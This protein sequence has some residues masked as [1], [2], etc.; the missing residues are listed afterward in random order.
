MTE[1]Y[2]QLRAVHIGCAVLTITIFTLRG[3]AMLVDSPLTQ[4][5]VARWTSVT[6]D[7]VLLTTA[8]MLTTVIH[9]Y[10]FSTGWLTVKVTLLVVYIVLG[11]IA[12]GR[13]R[14]RR[15]RITS[16]LAALVTVAFLVGV[17]RTHQPLGFFAG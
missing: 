16:F 13:G 1:F 12:L 17:A 14:T 8:L 6:V 5:P 4:H 11:S 10:P 9:Q 15:A 7:T 3:L 2:L